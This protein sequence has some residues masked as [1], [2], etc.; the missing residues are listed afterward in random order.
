M[1]KYERTG[2]RDEAISL[3]HRDWWGKDCPMVNFDFLALEYNH[4]MP[5]AIVEYKYFQARMFELTNPNYLALLNLASNHNPPIPFLIAYYWKDPW[6]FRVHPANREAMMF[7]ANPA[8]LS[9]QQFVTKL[10]Q[11]RGVAIDAKVLGRLHALLPTAVVPK[12]TEL[13]RPW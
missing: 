12:A 7:F 3:R 10:Y 2:W 9:E 8:Y 11:M 6:S 4:A 1:S 13:D 5:V